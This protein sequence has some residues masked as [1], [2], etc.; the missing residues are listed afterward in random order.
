M[1][2]PRG[3]TTKSASFQPGET[4]CT[5]LDTE[6]KNG[7]PHYENTWKCGELRLTLTGDEKTKNRTGTYFCFSFGPDSYMEFRHLQSY[8][9]SCM[10]RK[11]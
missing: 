6:E 3:E 8:G 1:E 10:P 4:I 7:W 11:L 9:V 5:T 2:P